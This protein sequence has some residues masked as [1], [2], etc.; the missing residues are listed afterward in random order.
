[1]VDWR[2]CSSTNKLG[3]VI[4]VSITPGWMELARMF[5]VA[6]CIAV[7]LVRRHTAPSGCEATS[8]VVNYAATQLM[9]ESPKSQASVEATG[10]TGTLAPTGLLH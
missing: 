9:A 6:Y 1:M 3:A 10:G 2:A 8:K 4:G 5:S 7:D